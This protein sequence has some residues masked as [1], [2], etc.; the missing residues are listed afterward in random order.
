[1]TGLK[2]YKF[3]AGKAGM[4]CRLAI[5]MIAAVF[6]CFIISPAGAATIDVYPTNSSEE[7][8]QVLAS[9]TIVL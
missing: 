4:E 9:S 8:D 2:N 5:F 7:F 3:N 1:M 6:L